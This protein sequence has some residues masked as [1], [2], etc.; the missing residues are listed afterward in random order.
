[1]TTDER[2]LPSNRQ[3]FMKQLIITGDDYGYSRTVNDA[4]IRACREG[5]LTSASL[6]PCGYDFDYAVKMAKQTPELSVGVHLCLLQAPAVLPHTEIPSLTDTNGNLHNNP[7]AGGVRFF[8]TP[9]IRNQIECEFRAQMAKFLATG[10]RPS[11]INTHMHLHA[12]PAVFAIIAQLGREHGIRFLRVPRQNFNSL[13]IDMRCFAHKLVRG[14]FFWGLS[15]GMQA[16]IE[17]AGFRCPDAIYG[18]LQSG[19]IDETYLTR[20]LHQLGEG[21]TEIYFHPGADDDPILQRWQPNYDHTGE[22]AALLSPQLKELIH[23]LGIRLT[24]FEDVT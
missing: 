3:H 19:H 17:R 18:L 12:H 13:W 16:K 11:H 5:I 9:G 4:I 6:M 15:I 23:T 8:V 20:V 14:A 7:F 1:M 2:L 22:T 10:L 24:R 21:V